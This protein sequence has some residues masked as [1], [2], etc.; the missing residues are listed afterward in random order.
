MAVKLTWFKFSPTDWFMGR[1]QQVPEDTQARF[2][3][4][5]CVYWNKSCIMSIEDAEMLLEK[6]HFDILVNKKIV[7]VSSGFI[8]IQFL[9]EQLEECGQTSEIKRAAAKKRWGKN[10]SADMHVHKSAIQNDADKIREEENREDKNIL[11]PAEK[12]ST[13]QLKLIEVPVLKF[14]ELLNFINEQTGRKFKKIDKSIQNKY[15]ARL[16]EGYTREDIGRAIRNACKDTKHRENGYKYLTPEFFSRADKLAL[17]GTD[18]GTV[19]T[20]ESNVSKSKPHNR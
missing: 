14:D 17:W 3:R 2:V 20:E 19:K 18:T 1:I 13:G 9:D 6:N 15:L 8:R 11:N 5:M 7:I 12:N 16:K 10:D 4:L